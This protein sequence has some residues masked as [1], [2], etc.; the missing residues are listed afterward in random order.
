MGFQAGVTLTAWRDRA[1]HDALPERIAVHARAEL[2]DDADR[3]VA[4]GQTGNDRIL[5][6]EDMDIGPADRGHGHLDHGFARTGLR[7]RLALER[8]APGAGEY[9]CVH[10]PHT[11]SWKIGAPGP[12]QP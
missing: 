3:L 7:Y 1:H 11:S 4:D 10:H 5:A 9:R 8:D 2:G 12:R 6:L